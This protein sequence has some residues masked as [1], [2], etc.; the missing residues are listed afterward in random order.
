MFSVD[1]T[2]VLDIDA[3]RR[4][5]EECNK[6]DNARRN[7][8]RNMDIFFGGLPPKKGEVEYN[9]EEEEDDDTPPVPAPAGPS[10]KKK[11]KKK[12]ST[13]PKP[14]DCRSSEIKHRSRYLK[15]MAQRI[16]MMKK[17][18]IVVQACY[19]LPLNDGTGQ[20]SRWKSLDPTPVKVAKD[21]KKFKRGNLL[22]DEDSVRCIEAMKIMGEEMAKKYPKFYKPPADD[23]PK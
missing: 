16:E 3:E 19:C 14:L 10:R 23:K 8:V 2:Q 18:G 17:A 9:D 15:R 1:Y 6:R 13:M 5:E 12:T 22:A 11:K 7:I 21:G 4:L 20:M